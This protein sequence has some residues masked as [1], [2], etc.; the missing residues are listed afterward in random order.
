MGLTSG[1][2]YPPMRGALWLGCSETGRFLVRSGTADG[3]GGYREIY[4]PAGTAAWAN[5]TNYDCRI[6]ALGG[7][8]GEVA[9]RVSDRSTHVVTFHAGTITASEL[10]LSND[11]QIENRGRYE[12]TAIREHTGEMATQI[13]VTDKT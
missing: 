1:L 4:T 6:D 7:G 9:E 11:L 10:S 2:P 5:T 13:E 12:I 3:G 8:E